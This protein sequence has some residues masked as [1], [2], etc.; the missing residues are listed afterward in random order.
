MV[1]RKIHPS[2]RFDKKLIKLL[3]K[4]PEIAKSVQQAFSCLEE[5]INHSL[6]KTHKLH[7]ELNDFYACKITYDCRLIF[8]YDDTYIYPQDI[9]THDDI[10]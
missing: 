4:D 9:G 10:Y 7:G 2:A 5:N 6:L 3:K 1:W 8:S